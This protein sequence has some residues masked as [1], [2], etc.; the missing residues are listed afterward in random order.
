[1]A[2]V[3]KTYKRHGEIRTCIRCVGIGHD[4]GGE[5]LDGLGAVRNFLKCGTIPRTTRA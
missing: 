3:Q 2:Y 5:E 4:R 1:M